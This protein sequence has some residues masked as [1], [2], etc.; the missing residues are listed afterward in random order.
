MRPERQEATAALFLLLSGYFSADGILRLIAD[1]KRF[2]DGSQHSAIFCPR[3]GDENFFQSMSATGVYDLSKE[4]IRKSSFR[5]VIKQA[6]L[7]LKNKRYFMPVTEGVTPCFM[8]VEVYGFKE[9]VSKVITEAGLDPDSVLPSDIDNPSR[10]VGI[11][12]ETSGL[13][14]NLSQAL[15][16]VCLVGLAGVA[17]FLVLKGSV[18]KLT[19]LSNSRNCK[20]D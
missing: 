10:D 17:S 20:E 6:L 9:V 18:Y 14:V 7:V 19:H 8:D 12:P 13:G 3:V 16:D 5:E 2:E 1:A 15:K 4:Q 11:E